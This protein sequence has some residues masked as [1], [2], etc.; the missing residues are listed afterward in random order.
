MKSN[1]FVLTLLTLFVLLSANVFAGTTAPFTVD[2]VF[3][4]DADADDDTGNGLTWATA[5]QKIQSAID[6]AAAATPVTLN[7]GHIILVKPGTYAGNLSLDDADHIGLKIMATDV[8]DMPVVTGTNA[9]TATI[10]IG[11]NADGVTI[12]GIKFKAMTLQTVALVTTATDCIKYRF[13]SCYFD[14]NAITAINAVEITGAQ[15]HLAGTAAQFENCTFDMDNAGDAKSA[16]L[17]TGT[18]YVSDLTI[19]GNTFNGVVAKVGTHSTATQ[20]ISTTTT[21]LVD[22]LYIYGNTFNYAKVYLTSVCGAGNDLDDIL[23]LGNFFYKTNGVHFEAT[24]ETGIQFGTTN[25]TI[26]NNHFNLNWGDEVDPFAIFLNASEEAIG[27][28]GNT[29]ISLPKRLVVPLKEMG[30]NVGRTVEKFLESLLEEVEAQK[31][32]GAGKE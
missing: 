16:I 22:G 28:D 7:W 5:K 18:A 1:I 31:K 19:K 21:A 12:K 3:Y 15:A 25:L 13:I 4:V 11:A 20:A 24:G 17:V 29:T 26:T 8:S 14:I 6:L 23:I 32:K 9:G 27:T 30:V 2:T 10:A